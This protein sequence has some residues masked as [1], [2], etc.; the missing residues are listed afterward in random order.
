MAS[1]PSATDVT[2]LIKGGSLVYKHIKRMTRQDPRFQFLPA[3]EKAVVDLYSNI[4]SQMPKAENQSRTEANKEE[5]V[6]VDD[7]PLTERKYAAT[8]EASVPATP[9]SRVFGFGMLGARLAVGTIT[10]GSVKSGE[11]VEVLA[12]ALCRMRGAAL[13]LGQMLSIQ[14]E[15]VLPKELTDALERVREG[16]DRMPMEQLEG[17]LEEDLGE[18]WEE[19]RFVEFD[20]VPIAAASLGQVHYGRIKVPV[21]DVTE[22]GRQEKE[23]EKNVAVKIQYPGVATSIDSDVKNLMTIVRLTNVVPKGLY[24]DRAMDVARKELKLECDYENEAKAQEHYRGLLRTD[25]VLSH[26]VETEGGVKFSVPALYPELCSKRVLTTEY[27]PGVPLDQV[28]AMNK[29]TRDGVGIAMLRLTLTELFQWNYM[30]TDPNW[31][32]FLFAEETNT[33]HLIDFGAA[34]SFDKAFVDQYLRMVWGAADRDEGK[35]LDASVKAG[36]LNGKESDEMI[37]AHIAAGMVVGE[38]FREQP[39]NVAFQ[40]G[41]KEDA[42]TSRVTGELPTIGR[43]RLQPPPTETYSLHRK[44]S[45]AFLAAIKLRSSIHCRDMLMEIIDGYEF[46]E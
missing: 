42:L 45:G 21:V 10:S 11:N 6:H 27:V 12:A 14:D 18:G 38:P 32:N 30:Q 22:Y 4:A 33:C 25:R 8:A 19:K 26:G 31:S 20:T 24:I 7:A 15:N 5:V 43:D 35:F 46:D 44:L 9:L 34:R 3:A 16:A 28:A 36:F 39:G 40:F 29:A 1:T 41:Q 2:R 37:A 23:V 13:K 17:I